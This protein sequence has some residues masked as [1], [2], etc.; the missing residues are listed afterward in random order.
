[1]QKKFE[2]LTVLGMTSLVFGLILGLLG[3]DPLAYAAI[4]LAFG[5]ALGGVFMWL[6]IQVPTP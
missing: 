4:G 5:I 1:M 6:L 2:Q 3:F